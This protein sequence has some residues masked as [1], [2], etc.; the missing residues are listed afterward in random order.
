MNNYLHSEHL[1]PLD[2]QS[3][4]AVVDCGV[5][6]VGGKG[7]IVEVRKECLVVDYILQSHRCVQSV[8]QSVTV[9]MS[10]RT[11]VAK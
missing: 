4:L 11:K 8:N 3:Q 7:A 5:L 10:W 6:S 2:G 9:S 1:L